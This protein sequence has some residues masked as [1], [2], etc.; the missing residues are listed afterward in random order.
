MFINSN[1]TADALGSELD[2]LAC[3]AEF[4][5][6]IVSDFD[7]S[8]VTY[9]EQRGFVVTLD[10]LA[11][12]IRGANGVLSDLVEAERSQKQPD[13]TEPAPQSGRRQRT[14]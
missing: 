3:F 9:Q 12:R 2:D 11:A 4:M 6:K 7:F 1:G 10:A 8:C 13:L 14:A 5:S